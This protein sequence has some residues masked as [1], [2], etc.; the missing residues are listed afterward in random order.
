LGGRGGE[1]GE[2]IN[3]QLESVSQCYASI[4]PSLLSLDSI[5][6]IILG[7][8]LQ[9]DISVCGVMKGITICHGTIHVLQRGVEGKEVRKRNRT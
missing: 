4:H 7:S 8:H 6:T 1:G 3:S 2:G 5:L 9:K